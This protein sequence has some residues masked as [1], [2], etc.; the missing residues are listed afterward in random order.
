ME[1]ARHLILRNG[2]RATTME[3]IAREAGIAKPTLY[4]QFA[5]K[6]AVFSG[7][8]DEILD[9]LAIAFDEGLAGQGDI[10]ER[11]GNAVAGQFLALAEALQGSPHASA[12][13][14][15]HR[16]SG[17][18]FREKDLRSEE[19][20]AANLRATGVVD[21]EALARVIMAASYG[22]AL[23]TTNA[24]TMAADIRLVCHRL[25]APALPK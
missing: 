1:A 13:M 20:I 6:D 5:D 14:T 16:R 3:G 24:A 8:V 11:V 18:Q 15:E 9:L 2:L 4:A 21:A 19:E 25:I 7:V 10:A 12:L 22:I 23:K 17:P